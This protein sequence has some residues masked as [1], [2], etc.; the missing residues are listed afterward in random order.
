VSS[1]AELL[2]FWLPGRTLALL[3]AAALLPGL[4]GWL[5]PPL[6]ARIRPRR[7]P[8]ASPRPP[9]PDYEI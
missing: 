2:P 4:W 6:L 8:A 3:L 7:P 1:P 9:L 5:L